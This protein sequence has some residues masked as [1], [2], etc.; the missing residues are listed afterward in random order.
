M[1]NAISRNT[2]EGGKNIETKNYMYSF[3]CT[4]LGN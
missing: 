3:V 4:G 1:D 2:K